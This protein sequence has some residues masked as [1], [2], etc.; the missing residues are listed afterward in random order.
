MS[1]QNLNPSATRVLRTLRGV[2]D[3]DVARA[4]VALGPERIGGVVLGLKNHLTA[5]LQAFVLKTWLTGQVAGA[6]AEALGRGLGASLGEKLGQGFA[7]M[8]KGAGDKP[9][10]G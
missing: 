4:L 5:E 3:D 7:D 2:S 9:T 1:S 6:G 8:F 10:D